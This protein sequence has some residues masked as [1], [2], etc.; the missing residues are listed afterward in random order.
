[1]TNNKNNSVVTPAFSHS[2]FQIKST[3]TRALT[4]ITDLPKTIV[5]GTVIEKYKYY[6]Y[7][8]TRIQKYGTNP[9]SSPIY[10]HK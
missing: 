10:I 4:V 9:P 8:Y 5:T 6:R 1:M 7:A 3:V 2:P